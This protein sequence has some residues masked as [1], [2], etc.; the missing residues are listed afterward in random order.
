MTEGEIR[1]VPEREGVN[2]LFLVLR[3]QDPCV[4]TEEKPLEL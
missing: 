1:E 2:L 4:E 3:G